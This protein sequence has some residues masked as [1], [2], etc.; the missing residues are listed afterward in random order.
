MADGGDRK[1]PG[2][3]LRAQVFLASAG[4]A[5]GVVALLSGSRSGGVGLVLAGAIGLVL[6]GLRS[7]AGRSVDLPVKSLIQEKAVTRPYLGLSAA[8]LLGA[9][10]YFLYRGSEYVAQEDP[11]AAILVFAAAL[12]GLVFGLMVLGALVASWL[13][14]KGKGG[15]LA[16]RLYPK[17]AKQYGWPKGK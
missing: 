11:V 7:R 10:A 17:L 13:F 15:R 6:A 5:V 1:P 4:I 8:M 14:A 9:A 3:P 12:L 2:M 16:A